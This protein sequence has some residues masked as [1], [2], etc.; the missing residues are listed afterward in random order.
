MKRKKLYII[1]SIII[2]SL[3]SLTIAY[4]VLSTTLSITGS[5]NINAATWQIALIQS[6]YPTVTTGSATYTTPTVTGTSIGNYSVSLT[7]PGDSVTMIFDVENQGSLNAEIDSVIN[8]IP[9]C[10][11]IDNNPNDEKLICDNLEISM[12]YN[13]I[14]QSQI[15]P[16]DV[17]KEGRSTCLV[18]G[19]KINSTT[20]IKIRIALNENMSSVATRKVIISNLSHQ[21]IYKQTDKE[22]IMDA[23][24]K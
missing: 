11:S 3:L 10:T 12:T 24:E 8:S 16:G 18:N 4:A 14:Y 2:I 21:I 15:S 19:D 13:S 5:A 9:T 23:P 17:L 22:C 7:K 6:G 1:L 20:A